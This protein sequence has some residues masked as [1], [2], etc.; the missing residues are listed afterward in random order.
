LFDGA[1]ATVRSADNGILNVTPPP[2][3]PGYRAVVAV[4]NPDGQS[5]LYMHGANSPTFVY[6][7]VAD[8][9]Q[10]AISPQLLPAG[11]ESVI[12]LSG[13]GVNFY[14]GTPK[15]GFGTTDVSVRKV[16]VLAANRAQFHVVIAP[17]ASPALTNVTVISGLQSAALPAAF[18]VGAANPRQSYVALSTAGLAPVY[19]GSMVTLPVPNL[20]A[21]AALN[22]TIVTLGDRSVTL[23]GVGAGTITFFVP[24][25]MPAGPAVLRINSSG[26]QTLPIVLPIEPLPLV[27]TAALSS[28]GVLLDSSHAARPGEAIN[29]LVTGLT[30]AQAQ[31]P[32]QIRV[33]AGGF[34]LPVAGVIPSGAQQGLYVI[35]TTIPQQ[36]LPGAVLP[37]LIS[38]EGRSSAAVQVAVR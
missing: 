28:T 22:N 16:W 1:A 23:G 13:T 10:F 15:L 2:G 18:L 30:E 35:Q 20:P 32:A 9:P 14:D 34:D 33:L 7:A 21:G 19:P 17:G 3:P 25:N 36:I 4:L 27:I 8:S 6:D 29:L 31:Q 38:V 37:I 24:A 11:V 12:E 26:D 5:S